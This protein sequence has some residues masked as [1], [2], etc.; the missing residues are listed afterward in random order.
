[1]YYIKK[2]AMYFVVLLFT[3]ATGYTLMDM[4]EASKT[5]PLIMSFLN[6]AVYIMMLISISF[7]EGQDA[8]KTLVANDIERRQIAKT[9]EDRPLKVNEEYALWKGLVIPLI[10]VSLQII[11]IVLHVV[12]YEII[13]S[14]EVFGELFFYSV[15]TI[16][17][18]FHYTIGKVSLYICLILPLISVLIAWGGYYLG[19]RKIQMQQ[20]RIKQIHD[21]IYKS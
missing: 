2:S 13:G 4:E 1:M 8:Y 19:A 21:Q 17:P 7:K 14:T 3:V 5:F 20:E 18:I 12:F 10:S 11:F 15:L 16:Y 6:L 9:G